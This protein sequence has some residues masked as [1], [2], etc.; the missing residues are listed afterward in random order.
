M[1]VVDNSIFFGSKTNSSLNFK[2]IYDFIA[3][4][5][6]MTYNSIQSLKKNIV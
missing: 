3:T 1:N 5:S 4:K 2:Y 6:W